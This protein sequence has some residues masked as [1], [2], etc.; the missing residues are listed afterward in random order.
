MYK[1]V[2]QRGLFTLLLGA[3]ALLPL[4]SQAAP[5]VVANC[6]PVETLRTWLLSQP[7]IVG[8]HFGTSLA[9]ADFNRDGAGEL[10]VGAPD[11]LSGGVRSGQVYVYAGAPGG[12]GLVP[13]P[14]DRLSPG[15]GDEY[16]TALAT[17]D[18]NHDG[19]P[20]LVVGAPGAATTGTINVFLGGR[21]GLAARAAGAEAGVV[22]PAAG[23][24]FGASVAVG[25]FNH[26]GYGDVAVGAPGRRHG[27]GAVFVFAGSGAGYGQKPP[28]LLTQA[29]NGGVDE[30]GDQFGAALAT[31]DFDGDGVVDLAVGAPGEA[32]GRAPAGG[33]VTVLKG[34]AAGL[35]A[36]TVLLQT[37]AGGAVEKADRFGASLAVGDLNGDRRADL[38]VGA[39]GETLGKTKSPGARAGTAAAK[40][41]GV[42]HVFRGASGSLVRDDAPARGAKFGAALAVGDVDR[43]GHA[44]LL[45]GAPGAARA[46]L[47]TAGL[48]GHPV[49]EPAFGLAAQPDGAMGGA[50]A[51]GDLTGDGRAEVAIAG[52]DMLIAGQ[53]GS[54]AVRVAS[55]LSTAVTKAEVLVA[56]AGGTAD[57]RV[58]ATRPNDIRVRFRVVGA[59]KWTVTSVVH[60]N[61]H[62][63]S[64]PL[65]GLAPA[66]AY[67]YQVIVGCSVDPLNSGSFTTR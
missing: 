28:T 50:V 41:A 19:Y 20:D 7:H 4:T 43:D 16:G 17:G 33:A 3:S 64:V 34:T 57:V 22:A 23:D 62:T 51:I 49:T 58:A 55:G 56:P 44:D 15:G 2:L 47:F 59:S 54:G 24:R 13:R 27:A 29:H 60:S 35:H 37:A 67:E 45:I 40:S 5:A 11:D 32:P 31:G 10:V 46:E 18:V 52:P 21:T 38:V 12:P 42:A 66:S 30:A 26:D 65:H 1:R 9:I 63:V 36:G 48:R 61:G 53:S 8:E 6:P 39:P 14:V 25:D